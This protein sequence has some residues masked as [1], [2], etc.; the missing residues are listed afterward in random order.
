MCFLLSK[1]GFEYSIHLV[2]DDRYGFVNADT[3]KANGMVGELMNGV[4]NK[5][6]R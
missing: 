6:L 3:G 1:K 2:R 5:S 4:G